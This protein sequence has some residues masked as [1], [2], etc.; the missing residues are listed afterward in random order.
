MDPLSP[1]CFEGRRPGR[2]SPVVTALLLTAV[3]TLVVACGGGSTPSESVSKVAPITEVA[4]APQELAP[5][6]QAP[7]SAPD[8]PASAPQAPAS[9]A[10]ASS[11]WT[12]VTDNAAF[13]ARDSGKGFVRDG[14]LFLS[15]GY[16]ASPATSYQDLWRSADGGLTWSL[17]AGSPEPS[18]VFSNTMYLPYSPIVEF[19]RTLFAVGSTVWYSGNGLSWQ[20]L[21]DN[22][23][24]VASEDTFLFVINGA[25][26]FFNTQAQQVWRSPDGERWS[27]AGSLPGAVGRCGA[28][29]YQAYGKVWL[30]GG[31]DCAYAGFFTDAWSSADGLNWVRATLPDTGADV[32]VAYGGRMW[33]CVVVGNRGIT[34]LL[35]GWAQGEQGYVNL[36]DV[37]YTRDGIQWLAWAPATDPARTPLLEPR[38]APTCYHRADTDQ[39]VV[40]AGKGGPNPLNDRAYVLNDVRVLQLPKAGEDLP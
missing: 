26:Y 12:K 14:A 1:D 38:H 39:L 19:N 6:P 4:S 28:S 16:R 2:L 17:L 7:A 35:G 8:T 23:P 24:G 20:H 21:T 15:T 13:G 32:S 33:P 18:E 36:N 11:V 3:L 27:L 29:M 31:G 25:L 30:S 9:A 5:P 37:W 10:S 34:W 40:V 22:G